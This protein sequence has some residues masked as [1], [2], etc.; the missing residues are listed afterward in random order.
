VAEFAAPDLHDTVAATAED[1]RLSSLVAAA[2][3]R[4]ETPSYE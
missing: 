1:T 4:K 3:C 2:A